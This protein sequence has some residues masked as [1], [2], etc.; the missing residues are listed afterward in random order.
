MRVEAIHDRPSENDK[1]SDNVVGH[2]GDQ[3][4]AA[5]ETHEKPSEATCEGQD[6]VTHEGLVQA[7]RKESEETDQ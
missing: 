6:K 3:V 4:H 7:T 1:Q 5:I 2:P